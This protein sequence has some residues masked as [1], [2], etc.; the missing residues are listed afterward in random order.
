ME[1]YISGMGII[2]ALG[3]GLESTME[4]IQ[5]EKTGLSFDKEEQLILGR[6]PISDEQLLVEAG[7][8]SSN[9]ISRT[10]VIGV[11]AAQ[12]AMKGV[13]A[14]P[15]VRTGFISGTSVG[16]IDL[17]E[18]RYWQAKTRGEDLLSLELTQDNGLT[19]DFIA[20]KLGI[21][22]YVN[23]VSTACS[24]SANSIMQGARLIQSGILDRVLVGGIDPLIHYNIKG[25][26]S[27]KIY[28]PALC[29]PF[30][31]N[32]QGLNLGEGAAFLLLE[33]ETS[34]RLSG[35]SPLCQITGWCNAAD[36]YHQT[37]SSPREM[38]RLRL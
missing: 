22:G 5:A 36:A 20:S 17:M 4:A 3:Y 13:E 7:I 24:S 14:H 8:E 9:M 37:A 10:S 38:G 2:S 16:G 25:F 28:S 15:T 21:S 29:R 19:T 27:L 12:E 18:S 32:R 31:K 6:I 26:S 30:D 33:N 11:L 35:S 23:T 1:V 34:L